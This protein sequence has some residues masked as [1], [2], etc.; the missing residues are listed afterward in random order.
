MF[1]VLPTPL[2]N[3]EQFHFEDWAESCVKLEG[4]DLV[5]AVYSR[6]GEAYILVA[7]FQS[8]S[9]QVN[10][11]VDLQALHYPLGGL[12]AAALIDPWSR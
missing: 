4:H 10:C 5:S 12:R 2:G 1:K 3:L 11:S 9:R 8:R 6:P 7:N